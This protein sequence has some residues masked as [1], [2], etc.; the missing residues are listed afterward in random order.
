MALSRSYGISRAQFLKW[1]L[2]GLSSP[3]LLIMTLNKLA[4]L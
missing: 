1:L 3:A 4:K 2:M